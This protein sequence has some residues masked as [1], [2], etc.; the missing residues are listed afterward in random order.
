MSRRYDD[1]V[2]ALLTQHGKETL[3]TPVF[4][5]ALG[6]RIERVQ[7]FDT[8]QL[9]TFAGEIKRLDGQLE[10]ARKK[11]RIGMD[12]SGASIGLASEGAFVA[13]PFG[14]LMPWNVEVLVWLDDRMQLEIVGMAQG[15]ARSLHR[16]LH[17]LDALTQFAAEAGFP[18]H[19]L[20]LRPQSPTDTRVRK[21]LSDWPALKQ[22]FLDCQRA[23]NNQTVYAENDHRAFC[24]PTRQ[25]MIERAAFDLLKKI[26][27]A[28]PQCDMPGFSIV[29]HQTGRPCR[30]CA[31]PT[32][33][34]RSYNWRCGACHFV[35]EEIA[36]ELLADPSR[37]D[38]CNP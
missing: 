31:R 35:K 32:A 3:L 1:Q 29:G 38:F 22:A 17:G 30:A 26:T 20:V 12:L 10:T 18:Q 27:S 7:G 34:A 4:E 24:S 21:G 25:A 33:L 6:C 37:C 15:P 19:H 11:A 28:C 13:D 9:G 36:S 5:P 14:G 8:D 23:S 2:I 16:A